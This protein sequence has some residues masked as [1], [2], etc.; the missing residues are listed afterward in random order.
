MTTSSTLPD[1][2]LEI[3]VCPED[4]GPLLYREADSLFYNPRLKRIYRIN[5][6]I[7]NL[8]IDDAET[9]DEPTHAR[10]VG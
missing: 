9:A 2:L 4:R 8:L 3:L 6:G 7:P 5:E 1:W 10:L